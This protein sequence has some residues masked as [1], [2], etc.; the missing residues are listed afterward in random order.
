MI[1]T[2]LCSRE[3]SKQGQVSWEIDPRKVMAGSGEK[4][5]RS[6]LVGWL[7]FCFLFV[8][9]YM[10]SSQENQE[11]EVITV[12]VGCSFLHSRRTDRTNLR[13]ANTLRT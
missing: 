3:E 12:T 10:V 1:L 5:P 2:P 4:W 13:S 9:S 7:G 6:K 11:S 8:N